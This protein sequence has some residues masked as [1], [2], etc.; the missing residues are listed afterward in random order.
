M[1][2]I[3]KNLT[4]KPKFNTICRLWIQKKNVV[5]CNPIFYSG[6]FIFL[7]YFCA[8]IVGVGS[9]FSGGSGYISLVRRLMY[10]STQ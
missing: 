1:Y 6:S 10:P 5:T 2:Y 8:P 4:L 7:K 9:P 3:F